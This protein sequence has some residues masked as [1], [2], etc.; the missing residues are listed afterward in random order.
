[1]TRNGSG[2]EDE[3]L[4]FVGGISEDTLEVA[5]RILYVLVRS[6]LCPREQFR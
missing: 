4:P 1:M 6:S 2:F 5:L 3:V